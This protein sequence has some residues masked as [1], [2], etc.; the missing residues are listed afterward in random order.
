MTKKSYKTHDELMEETRDQRKT[1][2]A[3]HDTKVAALQKKSQDEVNQMNKLCFDLLGVDDGAKL[4]KYL[5]RRFL[6][7]S[8]VRKDPAGRVDEH[9]TLI[10]TGAHEVFSGIKQM[11]KFGGQTK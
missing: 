5:E 1:L 2:K 6:G 9:A 11:I 3:Q 7:A 10:L 8:M 4:L